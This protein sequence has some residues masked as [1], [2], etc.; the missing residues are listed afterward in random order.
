MNIELLGRQALS[1]IKKEWGLPERGFLA[2]GALANIIWELVSGNTAILND[3]DIFILEYEDNLE[4][5]KYLFEYKETED[6]YFENYTGIGWVTKTK[7]YYK[8]KSSERDGIFNNISCVS[9]QKDI[10][11]I[12]NSFDI[13][14]TRVGYSIE[15]DKLYWADDFVEFLK[16]GELKISNLLTPAHT[17]IRLS[18]KQKDLN[19]KLNE[20]E[21]KLCQ[22]SLVN[23]FSDNIRFRF[24]DRY[25]NIY[26]NSS[27][28]LK[29]YFGIK[30]NDEIT[31]YVKK[32]Y[33]CD[34]KIYELI[35]LLE[36]NMVE[37]DYFN[38]VNNKSSIFDDNNLNKMKN[39]K[40][41]LFY[42]RNIYG[43]DEK[44]KLFSE[45][46]HLFRTNDYIDAEINNDDNDVKL[47]SRLSKWA[48]ASINNLKGYKLSEQIYIVKKL[49]ETYKNDPIIAI[50]IL[51][52][53]KI[54]KDIDIDEQTSLLLELSV[55]K[56]IVNDTKNK[57]KKILYGEER[58]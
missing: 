54:D 11:I 3:I 7:D 2:G 58:V 38:I 57:V 35:P 43:N 25:Y 1:R 9:N 50:S 33:D 19:A 4:N 48:P 15:E 12:L 5:S 56:K 52:D 45:L 34:D 32:N 14:A 55:R 17:A 21:Y 23:L 8:I 49:L 18:K 13:N 27:Q 42:M 29:K 44:S 30:V 16:S 47:L 26:E 36:S 20:F 53:I 24:K 39:S 40:D 6:L 41:F 10:L 46:N 28:I 51:E 22:H 31:N 37:G